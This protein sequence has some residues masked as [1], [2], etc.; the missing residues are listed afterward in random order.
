MC[1]CGYISV[2]ATEGQRWQIPPAGAGVTDDYEQP[3][4]DVLNQTQTFFKTN[5]W[6]SLLSHLFTPIQSILFHGETGKIPMSFHKE[7]KS[8]CYHHFYPTL[9]Q[10]S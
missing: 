7:V 1:M 2:G 8:Y 3:G 9:N 10:Q 6:F 5:P 4:V